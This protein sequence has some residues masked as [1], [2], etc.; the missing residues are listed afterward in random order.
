MST[1]ASVRV[2][3]MSVRFPQSCVH[4]LAPA[5][6]ERKIS[7][8]Q[9]NGRRTTTRSIQVPYCASCLELAQYVAPKERLIKRVGIVAVILIAVGMI[10]LGVVFNEAGEWVF[11]LA[12]LVGLA[13]P[14]LIYPFIFRP[15]AESFVEPEMRRRRTEAQSAIAI[16]LFDRSST[17]FHIANQA[18]AE[19]FAQC[20]GSAVEDA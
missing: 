5:T 9:S 19:A 8:S 15:W 14:F 20:N 2:Q 13:S 11:P 18:W 1:P 16:H 17:L 12:F 6:V 4:C 10:A 7:K 3:G